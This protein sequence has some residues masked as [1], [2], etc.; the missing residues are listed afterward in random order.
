M[1]CDRSPAGVGHGGVGLWHRSPPQRWRVVE[2]GPA[3]QPKTVLADRGWR[4]SLETR[5]AA[6]KTRGRHLESTHFWA[7]E[8]LNELIALLVL[9]FC[10]AMPSGL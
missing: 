1:S 6:L 10:G 5:F 8:R 3:R 2:A 9:G 4:W 7:A